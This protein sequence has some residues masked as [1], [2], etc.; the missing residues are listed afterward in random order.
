MSVP[1]LSK[2]LISFKRAT[3]KGKNLLHRVQILIEIT[4]KVL[5]SEHSQKSFF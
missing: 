5:I 2:T 4:L 1:P 3:L